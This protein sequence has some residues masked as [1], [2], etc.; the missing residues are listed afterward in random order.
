MSGAR[1]NHSHSERRALGEI[2]EIPGFICSFL[3]PFLGL[4]PSQTTAV[5]PAHT[6]TLTSCSITVG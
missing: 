6:I 3:L 1:V 4:R 5:P 2:P